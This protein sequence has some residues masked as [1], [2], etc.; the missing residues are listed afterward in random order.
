MGTSIYTWFLAVAIS[1]SCFNVS[2]A[3]TYTDEED[4]SIE[5][6]EITL[7]GAQVNQTI[8]ANLGIST[9]VNPRSATLT[10]RSVFLTQIGSLNQVS[11]DVTAEASEV[12]IFQNGDQNFTGLQ[13][14]A[15]T[16]ITN[17]VQNG[18]QNI[19]IDFANDPSADIS[20]DLTQNGDGL[21]FQRQGVNELTKSLKF[22]QTIGTPTLIIRSFN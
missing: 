3:Q 18:D 15:N 14:V 17:L 2:I 10:G 4:T 22:T 1:L 21:N 11:I 8:L 6:E 19:I 7:E 16:V 12:S 13:Y 5:G 20:L 9:G